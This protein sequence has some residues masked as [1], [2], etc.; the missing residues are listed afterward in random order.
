LSSQVTAQHIT[1]TQLR[2]V[3]RRAKLLSRARHDVTYM[4]CLDIVCQEDLGLRHFHQAQQLA[5]RKPSAASNE[6]QVE[7]SHSAWTLYL[8]ACHDAYFEL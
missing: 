1:E 6:T 8:Q 4:Q 7:Q 3:K 2:K 5:T